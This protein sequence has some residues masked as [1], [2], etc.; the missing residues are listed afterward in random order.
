MTAAHDLHLHE[1]ILLLA[2]HDRDGTV[3]SGAWYSQA[4]A[5][6]L[7]AELVLRGRIRAQGERG[8]L[9]VASTEPLG[10]PLLDDCLALLARTAQP[11][12]MRWWLAKVSSWKA[13]KQRAA[14][15][16]CRKG[17]LRSDT[18]KVL[19]FFERRV[20]PE[21]DPGPE[22]ALVERLRRVV[23]DDDENVDP[24]TVVLLSLAHQTNILQAVFERADLRRR[25]QRIERVV[26]GEA[27][28][29]AA[30]QVLAE[31]QTVLFLTTFI[32]VT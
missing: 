25:K 3:V 32:I 9:E 10:D 17:I 31:L 23:F 12:P 1:E 18:D 8:A 29:E 30:K 4:L 14:E 2:L 26:K 22:R 16:L 27:T 6:A 13:L 19:L 28:G 5:G 24:R 15:S 20:Y 7:L 21:V 11:K